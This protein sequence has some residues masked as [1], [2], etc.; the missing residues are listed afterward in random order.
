[1]LGLGQSAQA[2]ASD[3]A[4]NMNQAKDKTYSVPGCGRASDLKYPHRDGHSSSHEQRSGILPTE[5][6]GPTLNTGAGSIGIPGCGK[7]TNR[8][9]SDYNKNAR[10]TLANFD[11]SKMTE[12]RMNSKNVPIGCQDT[13]DPHFNGPIDQH[14]PGAGSPQSQ[15]HHIDAWNSVSSRRADNNNQ[16][17]MDPQTASSDRYN[18]KM[19]REE[20]SGVSASSYTTK[21]QGYP[22]SIPSFNQE[23]EEKETYAYGVGDRHNVPRNQ[24]MDET[25]PSANVLNATDHSISHPENKVLHK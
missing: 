2:Y 14:V 4:I 21:V 1:M 13:S 25:N 3:D 23:T 10:S 7:V 11:S 22:A 15:P 19:M 17:M 6:P 16:D 12:A 9:V 5:W 24:I 20:N 18:E 8:V